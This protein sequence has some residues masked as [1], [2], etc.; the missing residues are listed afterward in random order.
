[1]SATDLYLRQKD[2]VSPTDLWLHPAGPDTG[3]LPPIFDSGTLIAIFALSGTE[4]LA[5]QATQAAIN[6]LAGVEVIAEESGLVVATS[7]AASEALAESGTVFSVFVLEGV[8]ELVI[9]PE[10]GVV[11]PTRLVPPELW[12]CPTGC[13][14]RMMRVE[15]EGLGDSLN[16]LSAPAPGP[17]LTGCN[18]CGFAMQAQYDRQHRFPWTRPK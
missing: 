17:F 16:W 4:A 8:H 9:L 18:R 15:G 12:P 7:L 6:E 10:P 1:M 13:G 11:T 5:E 14:G 3:F 2:K